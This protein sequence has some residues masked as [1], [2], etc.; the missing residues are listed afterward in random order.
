[1]EIWQRN[2][3][4]WQKRAAIGNESENINYEKILNLTRIEIDRAKM[5]ELKS[6]L[7]ITESDQKTELVEMDLNLKENEP[8]HKVFDSQ[9]LSIPDLNPSYTSSIDINGE[10]SE[11]YVKVDV[12][13]SPDEIININD[14][15]QQTEVNELESTKMNQSDMT[16]EIQNVSKVNE[17]VK[18]DEENFKKPETSPI[19]PSFTSPSTSTQFSNSPPT[20]YSNYIFSSPSP[21]STS[22]PSHL[23]IDEHYARRMAI[24]QQISNIVIAELNVFYELKKIESDD[25][26]ELFK[27]MARAVTHFFHAKDPD[28]MP[29]VCDIK[30]Y[31]FEIFYNRGVIRSIEDF[32]L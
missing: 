2:V 7:K 30:N 6:I 15:L 11:D 12:I 24:K 13:E 19:S 9:K 8:I 14:K 25:P 28:K 20:P 3:V 32:V 29:S 18:K 31:I 27:K 1:V 26:K 16:H 5:E 10:K 23:V 22:S 17:N 21:T 4:P